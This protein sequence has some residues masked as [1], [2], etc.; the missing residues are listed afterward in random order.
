MTLLTHIQALRPTDRVELRW[1]FK[2]GWQVTYPA[3]ELQELLRGLTSPQSQ[4][5]TAELDFHYRNALVE[6]VKP[7]TPFTIP[8]PDATVLPDHNC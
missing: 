6:R 5:I 7:G 4:V 1:K 8:E 2:D 3:R